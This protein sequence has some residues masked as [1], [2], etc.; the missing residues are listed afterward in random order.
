LSRRSFRAKADAPEAT[1]PGA[2]RLQTDAAGSRREAIQKS[3]LVAFADQLARR[4]S[5][6][7]LACE[8]VHGRAGTLAKHSVVRKSPLFVAAEIEELSVRKGQTEV[9]LGLNTAVREEWLAEL[10]PGAIHERQ[11]ARLDPESKRVYAERVR[12][13]RDLP[14]EV[15]RGQDPDPGQA[16]KIL[17]DEVLAGRIT[18]KHWGHEAD[19]WILRLN[20]LAAACPDLALAPIT[21]ADRGLLVEQMCH[22]A[23][24]AREVK[25]VP[26][27]PVLKQWLS[28]AQRGLVDQ[29][30]PER[31]KL[32]NGRQPKVVYGPHGAHIEIRIQELYG[33]EKKLFVG[34]GRIPVMVHILAP[35][36]RPVQITDDLP[37]FWR[38]RYPAV[39]KE[40]QR[41]YPKHE[42]R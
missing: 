3:L 26:V 19:Q 34:M 38:D 7:T 11:E 16:A 29:Y 42:W 30:M 12:Y 33:V 14:L 24:S 32:P 23:Y 37:S 2:G 21:E 5:E 31:L 17:A 20:L 18:L 6:G 8:V 9:V 36:H 15:K 28:S 40:L 39:K 25:E 22:G 4:R 41:K 1:G 27:L 13:F 10:F 35:S